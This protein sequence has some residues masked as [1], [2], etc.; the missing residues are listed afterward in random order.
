MINQHIS[1]RFS[2]Y[3]NKIG[4]PY[5]RQVGVNGERV[6]FKTPEEYIKFLQE[7]E[8]A[9][10]LWTDSEDLLAMANLYQINVKVISIKSNDD[11]NPNVNHLGPSPELQPYAML[12][13]GVVPNMTLLHFGNVHYDLILSKNSRLFQNTLSAPIKTSE[14]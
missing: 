9:E 10:V 12:P 7:N 4:F 5:K 13:P 3:G 2:Y 1:D 8:K 11:T 14:V 6:N